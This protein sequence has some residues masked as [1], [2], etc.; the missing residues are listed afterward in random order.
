MPRTQYGV[1][2]WVDAF[3][4]TRRPNY[5]RFRGTE[6]YSAVIVGGG[7]TGC[8]TAYAFAA[9]GVKVAL[10][11]AD[12]LG[13]QGAGRGPGVL[14]GEPAASYRDVEARHGRKAARGLFESSRRAVLDLAAAARRLGVKS[15][16]THDALRV[17]ASFN[18][19]EKLLIKDAALRRDA[20]I[21]AVMVK[22]AVATRES[23]VE[24]ARGAMRLRDWGQCDPYELLVAFAAGAS[25][26]GAMIFERSRVKRIKTLRHN[27]EVHAANGVLQAD[28]V[29]IC[30]GEPTELYRSLKRHVSVQERY[31]VRTDRLSATVRRQIA[32]RARLITDT[33]AP[34][35]VI[36]WTA[37]GRLVIAGAEGAR[38]PLRIKRHTLVQRTGQLM[39]ELLRTYPPI[40]GVVPTHGWDLPIATSADGVMYAGPHRNYPQHL[41]AWATRHDPAQAFLASRILVRH[42]LGQAERE[43]AFFAFTRG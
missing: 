24:S 17:L 16:E 6:S 5:P 12:R 15:V 21:D 14:H 23:G 20:G 38:K 37:D 31:V 10:L 22:A 1:S 3:P 28:T 36:R 40:S 18:A 41:F 33:E 43:D 29:I 34:A 30:T 8:L 9:A 7:L 42:Y 35:H 11:E 19:E 27:V 13:L 32:A 25:E 2:P 39:Y 4:K 26:R